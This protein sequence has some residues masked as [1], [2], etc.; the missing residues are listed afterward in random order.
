[1]MSSRVL[2]TLYYTKFGIKPFTFGAH[3]SKLVLINIWVIVLWFKDDY[4]ANLS[5]RGEKACGCEAYF[6]VDHK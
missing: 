5:W 3:H 1:M 2:E 6:I 4:G